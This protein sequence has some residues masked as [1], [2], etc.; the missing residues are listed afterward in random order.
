M[1]IVKDLVRV[2]YNA[3]GKKICLFP[4]HTTFQDS[5]SSDISDPQEFYTILRTLTLITYL[6]NLR[7]F[8]CHLFEYFPCN[9]T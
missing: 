3:T 5:N 6:Y 2:H 1:A 8:K 7:E 9:L 4:R